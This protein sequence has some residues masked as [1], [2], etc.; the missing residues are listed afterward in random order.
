MDGLL[1]LGQ[2]AWFAFW[3]LLAC[4][5]IIY[6]ATAGET[7]LVSSLV[8]LITVAPFMFLAFSARF[9]FTGEWR[10]PRHELHGDGVLSPGR[11]IGPHESPRDILTTPTLPSGERRIGP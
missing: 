10:L 1:G 8:L 2:K 5:A 3:T 7:L 6:V 9:L 4:G 11:Q